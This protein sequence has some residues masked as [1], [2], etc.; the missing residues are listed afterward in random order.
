MGMGLFSM[1]E[2]S[3]IQAIAEKS[4]QL[5][6]PKKSQVGKRNIPAQIEAISATV[7]EYFKDSPAKCCRTRQELHDYVTDMIDAGIGGIDTETTGLDRQK[8]W[9][10]GSSLYYP[11]GVEIYIP[12]RHILPVFEEPYKD[13]LDYREVKEEF[14]RF[15]QKGTKL[16]FANAPFDLSM[17][18]NWYEID[19]TDQFYYDVI[20]SWRCIK[21]DEKSNRLKDLYNKYVLH[22]TGDP[23]HFSDFFS[24]ELFPYC[25]PEIAKLY[26]AHDPKITYELYE[27][28]VP[29][30]T[31]GHPRCEKRN[32]GAISDLI[33]GVEFPLI[34]IAQHMSQ[35]GM[36]IEKSFSDHLIEK[37]HSLFDNDVADLKKMI[38]DAINDPQYHPK[39]KSPFQTIDDL[40]IDSAAH[41]QWIVYDLLGFE[42]A[43]GDKSTDKKVIG[44][45][46]HPIISQ[47]LKCTSLSTLISSF[48]DKLPESVGKDGRVH[49]DFKT[50]GASTGRFS[51]AEPNTQ[52]IPSHV[53]DIRQMFRAK[54][55]FVILSSDFSQ[56]EP[57]LTAYVSQDENMIRSFKE[58]KDIYSF[59][60]SI[61]FNKTYEECLENLP[62]GEYD[63]DGNPIVIYQPDGKARRGE[64]KSVVLGILYGRSIPSI[65][66]QLYSKM[67]W[68]SDKKVK[69]AQYVYD[70]VLDAFPALRK[71][72]VNSQAFVKKYG[73]TET[74]LGRRRHIPDFLLPEFEFVAERGYVNPDIDPLDP[75]TFDQKDGI[76]DRILNALKK[77][78]SQYKYFGQIVRRTKE[79]A[80]EHIKVINNRKKIQKAQRKIV[81]SIIQGSAADTTK[82]AMLKVANDPVLK[83]LGGVMI[84]VIHDEILMECPIEHYEECGKRLAALMCEAASFLPFSIKCDVTT[85]YRWSGLEYPCPYTEPSDVHT[86]EDSEV[87][88]IQYHLCEVGYELPIFKK[89][90]GDKPDGDE[91]VGVNG[92]VTDAY[93]SC[94]S[95]YCNRFN[96]IED[97]FLNHIKTKVHT[98]YIPE[99][100]ERMKDHE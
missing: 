68:D 55:G 37:Y 72:M 70:S 57:K 98:G 86:N 47:I 88:W 80:E 85:S 18:F 95:D 7:K 76:P 60:A 73:Y 79:L 25:N 13:Q 100:L 10:V 41:K 45:F 22:G 93:L 62:T 38:I 43:D 29:L 33:W 48:V 67:D 51:C 61:A 89:P 23:K 3:E 92:R 20:T 36:F 31:K 39:K 44:L 34:K 96:I 30:I 84:N 91:A 27:W 99:E 90:N 4:K 9:I 75:S 65:A 21:E 78:F 52:N 64:A 19:L 63:E 82:L 54:S 1:A 28:Q 16:I 15:R 71:L 56:Q 42:S 8:D 59:I 6:A 11:G 74:I 94:I 5:E 26:A 58:N 77:E 40:N 2:I 49:P 83:E 87:R 97:D 35:Y 24:P 12:N 66:D 14:D 81:N 69:Q 32:L 50:I 46:K 53:K 17:M